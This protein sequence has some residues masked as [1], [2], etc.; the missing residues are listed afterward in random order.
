MPELFDG[1]LLVVGAGARDG[2]LPTGM[3]MG[4]YLEQDGQVLQESDHQPGG[5]ETLTAEEYGHYEQQLRAKYNLS[6]GQAIRGLKAL[7]GGNG[8]NIAVHGRNMGFTTAMVSA[9]GVD[10]ASTF[11]GEDLA[12]H[13]IDT[14]FITHNTN[15]ISSES[16]IERLE[17]KDRHIRGLGRSALDITLTQ[18]GI[19]QAFADFRPDIAVV[20]SAKSEAVNLW[21]FEA[22]AQQGVD[23]VT[24]LPGSSEWSKHPRNL[25]DVTTIRQPNLFIG[26]ETEIASFLSHLLNSEVDRHDYEKLAAQ[27]AHYA[28][29]GACTAGQ[30]GVFMASKEHLGDKV[31]HQP[32]LWAENPI[33]STGA[34]DATAAQLTFR[35]HAAQPGTKDAYRAA[36]YEAAKS[37]R[38]AVG[39]LGAT[40]NVIPPFAA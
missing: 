12:A 10:R 28:V 16:F 13:D 21:S 30:D 29:F 26:N 19:R 5:K 27:L 33:D 35:L 31:L 2:L 39:A 36:L 17:G 7:G 8:R 25:A 34:G 3:F 37:G 6:P 1:K 32:A 11:I 40:G 9:G 22:A 14:R 20:T 38:D 24:F 23:F 4:E 18:A 15:H